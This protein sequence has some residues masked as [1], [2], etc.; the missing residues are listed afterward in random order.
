MK[1]IRTSVYKFSILIFF[2]SFNSSYCQDSLSSYV[3]RLFAQWDKPNSPGCAI[4]IVKN[5]TVVH[6]R[7]Y[8]MANLEYD[9]PITPASIF[10]VASISK[11]FTAFSILLLENEGKISLDDDIRKYLPELPDYGKK[12]TIR[13]L[14]HHTSGL[15]DQWELLIA[16]GW[17]MD[18][19]IT[20][21]QLLEVIQNQKSL[22]FDP[23]EKHLYS[24]TGYTLL[25]EIV[26]RISGKPFT[27]FTKEKIFDP[28]GMTQTHF[29]DDNEWIVKNRTYPFRPAGKCVY[30]HDR[31]NFSNVGATSLFTTVEDFAKW[32][33]N[34]YHGKVG[35]K[36]LIDKMHETEKLNNGKEINYACGL[37]IRDYKGQKAVSHTG[38]DAGYR[39]I[40]IRFPEHNFS[41]I[42]FSN[43]G[44][45]NLNLVYKIADKY[46]NLPSDE[47]LEEPKIQKF[48]APLKLSQLDEYTGMYANAGGYLYSVLKENDNLFLQFL[49]DYKVDLMYKS[50]DKFYSESR[51]LH[52]TFKRDTTGRM[53]KFLVADKVPFNRIELKKIPDDQSKDYAGDYYNDELKVIKTVLAKDGFLYITGRNE[54]NDPLI[55]IKGN[56]FY[57]TCSDEFSAKLSKVEFLHNVEGKTTG[58]VLNTPMAKNLLFKKIDSIRYYK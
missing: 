46:L 43:L 6:K 51:N 4:A 12:I 14:I 5:G 37:G 28:L 50:K 17:R 54:T 39:G 42:L 8:G 29:H 21:K 48:V 32:D 27:Q 40:Y 18:D 36:I 19:I 58:Y 7:R 30:K 16:A 52:L 9:I 49:N 41:V 31:L 44:S 2:L 3:D 25:A 15:K 22:N 20:Q 35:G 34:F 45:F 55:N 26:E 33:Q 57:K 38:G 23:G 47:K 24:N 1:K 10:H 11:Q 56:S 13:H 53:N